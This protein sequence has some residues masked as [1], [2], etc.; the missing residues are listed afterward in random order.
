M[1]VLNVHLCVYINITTLPLSKY[2]N[3]FPNKYCNKSMGVLNVY[4][5]V[6]NNNLCVKLFMVVMF[7]R[8]VNRL[9]NGCNNSTTV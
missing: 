3:N 6:Y 9:N 7:L 4:L 2:M 1:S 8:C 5:C